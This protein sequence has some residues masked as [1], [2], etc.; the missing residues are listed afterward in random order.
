MIRF[1]FFP[2]KSIFHL[3]L[4][5]VSSMPPTT[6][7][8]LPIPMR[9][10][11]RSTRRRTRCNDLLMPSLR[12]SCNLNEL[13]RRID[14][15]KCEPKFPDSRSTDEFPFDPRNHRTIPPKRPTEF[16][17]ELDAESGKNARSLCLGVS[18]G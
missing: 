3:Q 2:V 17:S 15:A 9:P 6:F 18:D 14:A 11:R 4:P 5:V 10:R 7:F 13:R 12:L 1:H 8:P 16:R